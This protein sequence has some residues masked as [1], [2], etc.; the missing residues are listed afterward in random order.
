MAHASVGV[1]I[2]EISRVA[3]ALER[4]PGFAQRI[5]TDE[6]RMYC[7]HTARP[8][9][10]YAARFAA[11]EAV[12][13]MLGTGFSQGIGVKDVSVVQDALGKPHVLLKNKAQELAD[14][15]GILEVALSLSCTQ[16]VAIANAV[17]VTEEVKPQKKQQECSVQEKLTQSF[18]EARS[19][20]DEIDEQQN[21]YRENL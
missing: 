16:N 21:V 20:L 15:Q 8:A 14:E 5:F 7:E 2:I 13:K 6:E 17:A 10:H 11:R 9:E 4:T 18:R 12:L 1:D 19:L 3:R